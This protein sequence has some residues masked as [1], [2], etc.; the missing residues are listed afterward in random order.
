M[1][2]KVQDLLDN[3]QRT[4]CQVSD[5]AVDAGLRRREKG[6]GTVVRGQAEHPPGGSAGG[7]E[8]PS[9]GGG[10]MVYATHTGDPTES[11]VLLAKL[12][13]IDGLKEQIAALEAEIGRQH[14]PADRRL[15]RLRQRA[16]GG[17][18]VLPGVR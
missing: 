10:E 8:P 13:E 1:N 9:A 14:G 3:V 7:G 5:V 12:Q 17:R 4:A 15:P 11:E 16:P 2:E 18:P 6:R